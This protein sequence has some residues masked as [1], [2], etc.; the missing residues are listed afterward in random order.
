[1]TGLVWNRVQL[2]VL[3]VIS[4]I[5]L[6]VIALLIFGPIFGDGRD[7]DVLTPPAPSC[8]GDGPGVCPGGGR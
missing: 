8:R 3:I 1:M 2:A 6:L 5:V 4:G 7:E